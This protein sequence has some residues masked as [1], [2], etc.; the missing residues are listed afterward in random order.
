MCAAPPSGLAGCCLS[1][2]TLQLLILNGFVLDA[3]V[4]AVL[5]S[6]FCFSFFLFFILLSSWDCDSVGKHYVIVQMM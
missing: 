2:Y 6:V 4:L 1:C 5:S 3:T